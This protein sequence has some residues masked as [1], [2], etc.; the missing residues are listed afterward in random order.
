V[1]YFYVVQPVPDLE[2]RRVK[3]GYTTNVES[4]LA[5]YRTISPHAQVLE[6][7]PCKT[8]WEAAAIDSV[9]R[10]ECE[11]LGGEVFRCEDVNRLIERADAFFELMPG[12]EEG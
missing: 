3:L 1:G 11:L 8:A 12:L 5:S 6:T 10:E 4:R 7:W 9:T 2:P